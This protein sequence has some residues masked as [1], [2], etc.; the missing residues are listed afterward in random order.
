MP[1]EDGGA[2]EAPVL[3]LPVHKRE[4][5]ESVLRSAPPMI[6]IKSEDGSREEDIIVPPHLLNVTIDLCHDSDNER[7]LRYAPFPPLPITH[8]RFYFSS[9]PTPRSISRSPSTSNSA[10]AFTLSS[11]KWP[12]RY[13]CDMGPGISAVDEH[14]NQHGLSLERGFG[15]VFP[16]HKYSQSTFSDHRKYWNQLTPQERSDVVDARYTPKGEWSAVVEI[17]K[18]RLPS[19]TKKRRQP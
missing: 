12:L 1:T 17:A 2:P 14:H 7:Y 11:S 6:R 16:H 3:R 19:A 15:L 18:S 13:A 5:S 9:I 4:G 8:L 10:L